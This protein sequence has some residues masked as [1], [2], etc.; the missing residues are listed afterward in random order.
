MT[1]PGNGNAAA[2]RTVAQWLRDAGI[3]ASEARLLLCHVLGVP[4]TWLITHDTDA[5]APADAARF[6]DL[7]ARRAAG[8]PIAYLLGSRE[9]MG[10]AFAVS[11]DVLIPRPETELLVETGLAHVAGRTRPRILDLG[12]GSGAIAISLALARPD[13]V[14]IATDQSEAA[15]AVARANARDLGAEVTFLAG[16]WWSALASETV[17]SGPA[18]A[19]MPAATGSTPAD[20]PSQ[21]AAPIFDLIVSNPPY[22]VAGDPHLTQGDLRFEPIDALTDHADGLAALRILAQGAAARLAPGGAVWFEHG[23]DQ[24]AAVRDLLDQAGL[25]DARSLRDLAGIERITGA[26]L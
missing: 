3:V 2:A 25:R 19:A 21:E 16:D 1:T 22:I 10:H 4:R 8:E 12:T 6:A 15:L 23:Y 26:L 14:V 13:A 24:A 11:P 9:F 7:T 18:R 17:A 20:L 5:I